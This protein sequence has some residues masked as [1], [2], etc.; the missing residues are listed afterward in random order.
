MTTVQYPGVPVRTGTLPVH[1]R[2][3]I[4]NVYAYSIVRYCTV[5]ERTVLVPVP[6]PVLYPSMGLQYGIHTVRTGT[7]NRSHP[8]LFWVVASHPPSSSH[9]TH[10]QPTNKKV[11]DLVPSTIIPVLLV[12]QK[13]YRTYH[14]VSRFL[15]F[16]L[17][18]L[19]ENHSI[20]A[21]RAFTNS[22]VQSN[23]L[24]PSVAPSSSNCNIQSRGDH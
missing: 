20:I 22:V 2:Y 4:G 16:V 10:H 24:F 3:C 17:P 13:Q 8:H 23:E 11:W 21:L 19:H 18:R 12:S 15:D 6:V 1:Y 7:V 14:I 5:R 9:F